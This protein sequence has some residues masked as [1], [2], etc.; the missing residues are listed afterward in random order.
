MK[1]D[2]SISQYIYNFVISIRSNDEIKEEYITSQ[3]EYI[4]QGYL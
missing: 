3:R 2:I 1:Y 4:S